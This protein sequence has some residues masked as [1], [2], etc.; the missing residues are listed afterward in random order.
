MFKLNLE[1]NKWIA[2]GNPFTS[3]TFLYEIKQE[4]GL[5]GDRKVINLLI[6]D[7]AIVQN[8]SNPTPQFF[9]EKYEELGSSVYAFR[10]MT[11]ALAELIG[12]RPDWKESFKEPFETFHSKIDLPMTLSESQQFLNDYEKHIKGMRLDRLV[13][14]ELWSDHY[15]F[16]K[17]T[18]I[19]EKGKLVEDRARAES[20]R[21][22]L[23]AYQ[24]EK[25]TLT[26]LC[27]SL[28]SKLFNAKKGS[29]E[30]NL[31]QERITYFSQEIIH[32]EAK[33]NNLY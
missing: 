27:E 17:A 4:N 26:K 24:T 33:I 22:D 28:Q 32:L 14:P 3:P 31:I 1:G 5:G 11:Q 7:F 13:W 9:L 15:I 2:Q 25:K 16:V 18:E 23:I 6:V 29:A 19:I 21:S 12:K 8:T 10:L 20:N 30:E